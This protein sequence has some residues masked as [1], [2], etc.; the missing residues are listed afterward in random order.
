MKNSKKILALLLA[1]ALVLAAFGGCGGSDS[2][3]GADSSAGK[4]TSTADSETSDVSTSGGDGETHMLR[5]VQPGTLPAEYDKGIAAVN[6]K[7]KADGVNVDV[8][9]QRIPWDSYK[10]KLN[11]MLTTGEE[12]EM[13]HVMNDVKT[14]SSIAG[15]GAL[16]PLDEYLGK[17]P[18][19]VAKFTDNEW[20]GTMYDGKYYAVPDA[21]MNMDGY[22]TFLTYR[23][24]VAQKIGYNSFPTESVDDVLDFMKKSQEYIL[25]ETGVKAYHWM[26][27]NNDTAH[28]L[29]RSY[30]TYPFYVENS[31]GLVLSRQDGTIDSFYESEEF[32]QDCDTYYRMYQDGL[33]DPDVLNMDSQVKYTS[34]VL[35]AFLPS[36]HVWD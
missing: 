30:D 10:E 2:S 9:I 33:I 23:E 28:W 21:W 35:G 11:L 14:L 15:M 1:L 29:H 32:R 18:D 12:F 7:L 27:Q 26:H 19:L 20:R 24:D 3:S 6:E 36:P 17:Y 34:E 4:D 25:E 31:L 22:H 8:S 16:L 5:I 13:L